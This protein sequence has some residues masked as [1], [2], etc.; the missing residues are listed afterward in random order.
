M[1]CPSIHFSVEIVNLISVTITRCF[2][3]ACKYATYDPVSIKVLR[4]TI[5]TLEQKNSQLF[6]QEW[7][8]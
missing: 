4:T 7:I 6:L 2:L 8:F 5:L 1:D 3:I